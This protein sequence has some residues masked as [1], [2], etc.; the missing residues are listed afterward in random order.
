MESN[1][2]TVLLAA[3]AIAGAIVAGVWTVGGPAQGAAERRDNTRIDDLRRLSRLVDCEARSEGRLPARLEASAAC[4][5]TANLADPYTG[6]PYRYEIVTPTSYRICADF[7]TAVGLFYY[8]T[9]FDAATGCLT[10]RRSN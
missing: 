3:I 4:G 9:G 6:A 5:S 7:E 1:R 10:G 2:T 8:D